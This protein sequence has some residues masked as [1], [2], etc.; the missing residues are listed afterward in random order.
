MLRLQSLREEMAGEPATAFA[1][2]APFPNFKA[3]D[4]A[5]DKNISWFLKKSKMNF[6]H[7]YS[8]AGASI[9][10]QKV[11]VEFPLSP[12]PSM[13]VRHTTMTAFMRGE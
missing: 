7:E 13:A 2:T 8:S 10:W 3:V 5:D 11:G 4:S 9:P 1:S 12:W 6:A